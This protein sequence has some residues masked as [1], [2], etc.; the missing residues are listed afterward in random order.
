[1]MRKTTQRV[2]SALLAFLT[3]GMICACAADNPTEVPGDSSA[4]TAATTTAPEVTET[5]ADMESTLPAE[6]DFDGKPVRFI[7]EIAWS[8]TDLQMVD[9][10]YVAEDSADIVNSAVYHR[11][12]R[13]NEYLNTSIQVSRTVKPK[14]LINTLNTDVAAGS[15]D[16]D[17]VG[18]F[19]AYSISLAAS[20]MLNPLDNVKHLD[21]M[22]SYW[23]TEYLDE[24]SYKGTYWT[25]GDMTRMY[26]G[27]IYATF[28][29]QRIWNNTYPKDSI[30]DIVR[31]G[32]WT[33]ERLA[34]VAADAYVDLDG[35][36]AVSAGDT[37]GFTYEIMPDYLACGAEVRYSQKSE[38]G[39][40]AITIASEHTFNVWEKLYGLFF[41][42]K[43]S[44]NTADVGI[45][46]VITSFH[47]QKV[48]AITQKIS[49]SVVAFRDMEDDFFII[50][51]PKYDENQKNYNTQIHD[52]VTLFGIPVTNT[53]TDAAGAVLTA[54]EVES[55]LTV[56]PIYYET[57]L[58]QKYSRDSESGE[59]ID[60]IRSHVTTDFV[61]MYS[62][63]IGG[64]IGSTGKGIHR[65]LRTAVTNKS[66]AVASLYESGMPA[67]EKYLSELLKAFD[68]LAAKK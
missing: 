9:S 24:M 57:A 31:D 8:D 20:G 29:N 47:D 22:A 49:E 10:I 34:K 42:T 60:L 43:G 45:K 48:L 23:P 6:L 63:S 68:D 25:T 15:C 46:N 38:K 12:A 62:E 59:M 7:I 66:E 54:M 36:G 5:E 19:Q 39:I 53:A 33:I 14:Q 56:M 52:N 2:I 61:Y 11:N 21:L 32:K 13:I 16:Y 44:V 26:T 64:G 4:D 51:L 30:Y 67:Y 55:D 58:K 17:I 37:F 65:V 50:P 18:A 1:M 40:P 35:D 3:S 27:G 41:N 28:V